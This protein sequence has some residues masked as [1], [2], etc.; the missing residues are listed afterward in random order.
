MH[1]TLCGM[2]VHSDGTDK[3]QDAVTEDL[4]HNNSF[5]LLDLIVL[6]DSADW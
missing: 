5:L 3:E 2:G 4:N 6:G 1:P